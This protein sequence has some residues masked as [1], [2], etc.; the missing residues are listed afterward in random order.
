MAHEF[1][2][3]PEELDH[4]EWFLCTPDVLH[5]HAPLASAIA[6]FEAAA[7]KNPEA[8]EEATRWLQEDAAKQQAAVTRLMVASGHLLGFYVL[9]S[10]EM[11]ISATQ[12][13]ETSATTGDSVRPGA[14]GSGPLT[15]KWLHATAAPHPVPASTS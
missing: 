8:A 5:E 3:G 12:N 1:G 7:E 15:S 14:K 4:A 9:V 13:S 6:E 10:A 2:I 11:E